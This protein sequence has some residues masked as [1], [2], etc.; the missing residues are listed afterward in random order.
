MCVMGGG[1]LV[2][3]LII[4]S[5]FDNGLFRILKG[6]GT[7]A[8]IKQKNGGRGRTMVRR[9]GRRVGREK[10]EGQEGR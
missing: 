3:F 5:I 9:D 10:R 7:K 4:R 1:D 8:K 2:P 6:G